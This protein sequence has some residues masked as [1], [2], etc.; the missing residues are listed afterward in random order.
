M[1]MKLILVKS[2]GEIGCTLLSGVSWKV[3]ARN[4]RASELVT[5]FSVATRTEKPR[6]LSGAPEPTRVGR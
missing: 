5:F 1:L 2:G 6:E 3:R 4:T